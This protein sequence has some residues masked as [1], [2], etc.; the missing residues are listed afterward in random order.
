MGSGCGRLVGVWGWAAVGWYTDKPGRPSSR[1]A[2]AARRALERRP[3]PCNRAA[4][5]SRTARHCARAVLGQRR[6]T[7]GTAGHHRQPPRGGARLSSTCCRRQALS[8]RALGKQRGRRNGHTGARRHTRHPHGPVS[9]SGAS[10]GCHS[11]SAGKVSARRRSRCHRGIRRFRR[12]SGADNARGEAT[13]RAAAARRRR[14]GAGADARSGGCPLGATVGR[15]PLSLSIRLRALGLPLNEQRGTGSSWL[16]R[17]A[18]HG[19]WLDCRSSAYRM[20]TLDK[21]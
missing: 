2:L 3:P 4:A 10:C 5:P 1:H 18:H 17:D 16:G 9:L 11:W 12:R 15:V 21:Q 6:G 7:G 19:S 20:L 14:T 8:R 13:G